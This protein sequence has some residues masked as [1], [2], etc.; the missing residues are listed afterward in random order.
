MTHARALAIVTVLTL[1]PLAQTPAG[2]SQSPSP[3]ADTVATI[4]KP[5]RVFDGETMHEGWAVPSRRA[6]RGGRPGAGTDRCQCT[7]S[8]SRAR[9]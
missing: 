7:T 9:R 1:L 5:S 6:H 8:I 2:Q 3:A 4:L